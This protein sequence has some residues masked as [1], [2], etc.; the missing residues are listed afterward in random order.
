MKEPIITHGTAIVRILLGAI[1]LYAGILKATDTMAFAGSIEAY[2]ILPYFGNYLVA[3]TLPWLEILCGV[4]LVTGWRVRVAATMSV[5]M[6]LVFITAL[7]SAIGRGLEIDC[8]CF[9]QGAKDSP[10]S[11][12]VRDILFIAMAVLVLWQEWRS[13]KRVSALA[14]Q[15]K[16][17]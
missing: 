10:F 6:N 7:L 9:K 5:L 17:T 12:I 2:R 8:G 14:V 3:A 4:L 15:D 16:I 1:F 11:A 13:S